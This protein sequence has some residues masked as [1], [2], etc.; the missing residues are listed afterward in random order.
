MS[1]SNEGI[2]GDWFKFDLILIASALDGASLSKSVD[3]FIF[4]M[5][6]FVD[7]MFFV[8]ICENYFI[9]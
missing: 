3:A 6:K 4:V 2:F 9:F 5:V 1:F 8:L 7:M